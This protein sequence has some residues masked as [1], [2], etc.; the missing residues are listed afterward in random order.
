MRYITAKGQRLSAFTLGTVQL[1][2]R[3]GLGDDSD[4]PSESKAFSILDRAAE[5]G[6]NNLDTANNYGDSDVVIGHWLEN[7]GK[8]KKALPLI[9]TKIGPFDHSSPSAL[10]GDMA[11]QTEKCL[12]NLGTDSVDCLMLHNISDYIASP[13]ETGRFMDRMKSEGVCA[14]TA[15]SSY[16]GDDFGMI[17]DSGF[18]AVQIPLNVFDQKQIENGGVEKLRRAGMMIFARSV[19]LQG[20]VFHTPGTLSD[21]MRFCAPWLDR[22]LE[23]T[24]E[25]GLSP[26]VLALSFVLSVPGVTTAVIG[27]DNAEQVEA[28][29]GL[30]D[31]TV[32]LTHEQLGTLAGAFR[33]IDPRVVD[34]RKW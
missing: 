24:K 21:K 27:C 16:S 22:Y 9:T 14:F 26:E 3:Y 31:Q 6:I 33:D 32:Q 13:D 5:L 10:Q 18:D 23:L 11:R 12:K 19:F 20:L 28:N 17:A 4:K 29:A 7:R 25:F 8:E 2:M 15:L 30:F 34:P 1:G